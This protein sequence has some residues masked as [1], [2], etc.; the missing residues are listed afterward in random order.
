MK[1]IGI[2][3]LRQRASAVL[4]HVESGATVDVT[5]RGRVVARLVPV[6][7]HR[8]RDRLIA[9]GRLAPGSGDV[10]ELDAPIRPKPGAPLPSAALAQARA[11]ER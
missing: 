6:H 5:S 10:L 9:Q 4:K 1:T 8:T 7:Q 11:H 3:E 2:R